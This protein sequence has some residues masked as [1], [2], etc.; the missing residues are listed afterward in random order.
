MMNFTDSSQ[1]IQVLESNIPVYDILGN[2]TNWFYPNSLT[3]AMVA[4]DAQPVQWT[5]VEYAFLPVNLNSSL[6]YPEGT[7][8]IV[9]TIGVRGSANCEAL[10]M[11]KNFFQPLPVVN[12]ENV[13]VAVGLEIHDWQDR[14]ETTGEWQITDSYE[15]LNIFLKKPQSSNGQRTDV[16]Q[17]TLL[18]FKNPRFVFLHR[19]QVFE[20]VRVHSK[21]RFRGS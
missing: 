5:T 16:I 17:R 1:V 21:G 12:N 18:L 19:G 11:P 15:F 20:H 8:W 6:S 14:A 13:T 9:S 10:E 3:L 7:N 4:W 2:T